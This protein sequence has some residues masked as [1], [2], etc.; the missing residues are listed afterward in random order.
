MSKTTKKMMGRI[1]IPKIKQGE[2]V[3]HVTERT[4]LLLVNAIAGEKKRSTLTA[5]QK[6]FSRKSVGLRT[7]PTRFVLSVA[8]VEDP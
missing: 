6:Q 2:W 5:H 3:P 4:L 8:T 1:P 7:L